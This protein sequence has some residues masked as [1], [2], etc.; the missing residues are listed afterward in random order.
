MPDATPKRVALCHF[1]TTNFIL[2]PTL[3]TIYKLILFDKDNSNIQVIRK[4]LTLSA[5][6]KRCHY[7]KSTV[8]VSARNH[9]AVGGG[10]RHAV[11]DHLINCITETAMWCQL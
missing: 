6:V 10:T 7:S 8:V 11:Q 2:Q 5:E 1:L 4:L 9:T 3:C